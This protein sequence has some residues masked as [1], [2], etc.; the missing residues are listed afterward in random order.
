MW[1]KI[2]LKDWFTTLPVKWFNQTYGMIWIMLLGQFTTLCSKIQALILHCGGNTI[3]KVSCCALL[4]IKLKN[5]I[6]SYAYKMFTY[7]VMHFI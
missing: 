7:M 6:I 3:A 4:W 1:N 2:D 5:N